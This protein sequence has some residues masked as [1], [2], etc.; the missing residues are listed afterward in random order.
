[1]R[2]LPYLICLLLLVA[3]M[4]SCDGGRKRI[5]HEATIQQP[6][7]IIL[8]S[9]DQGWGDL[10]LSGNKN[11]QTPNIDLLATKGVQFTQFYVSPVCSPTRAEFLTGR[12]HP[13]CGVYSTSEGGERINLDETT[14]AQIFKKAG[15]ATAAFGKWHNG[16]QYPYHPNGR[17]FDEFYGFCSGHWGNY[18]SPLLE[19]NGKLVKGNGFIADDLTEKAI[20]FIEGNKNKPFFLYV[21]Y[22]TPHSPMQVPDRWWNAFKDKPLKMRADDPEAEDTDFTRAALAM[23]ENLDWNVGRILSKLKEV[24][25]EQNTIVVYLSDNGPNGW[26]WNGGMKGR[27]GSTDEGGIRSPLIIRWPAA[28]KAG[29]QIE[30]IAAA[31]DLFPTLADLAGIPYHTEKPLDGISLKPLLL[32][33]THSPDERLLFAHWDGR[34][35]VR[36]GQYR[37]DDQGKLYDIKN[38][39]GQ[40]KDI[41]DSQPEIANQLTTAVESWKGEMLKNI[42][43]DNRPLPVGHAGFPYTQL[44]ARDGKAHGRIVRSNKYPNSSFFTNWKSPDDRLTWEV[45]VLTTGDYQVEIY[46]TCPEKDV[47]STLQVSFGQDRIEGKITQ[48]QE[49]KLIGKENDR[50]ERMESYEQEFIPMKMGSIHLEKGRGYITLQALHIPGSQVMDFRLLMLTKVN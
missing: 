18:F 1:M 43:V 35:S 24:N 44:P 32:N 4:F 20:S 15:Y 21:P 25:L 22:N 33:Q 31:I 41:S 9:D 7:I 30:Q 49:P 37:L 50:V 26:R 8:M 38:D 2:S 47:G 6:N 19:H 13:R 12:Y 23:C 48:A 5:A 36:K 11:L 17:G 45:E 39:P 29:T 27:K 16:M 28:I 42:S 46:Y 34:V 40:E 3:A 10:S 14:I